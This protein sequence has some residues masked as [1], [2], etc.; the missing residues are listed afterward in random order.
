VTST[1]PRLDRRLWTAAEK[2]DDPSQPIAETW[3]QVCALA[4]ELGIPLPGYDTIRRIVVAHRERRAEVKR[5]LDP[6]ITDALQG[7][8][9]PWDLDRMIEAGIVSRSGRRA[10]A[11]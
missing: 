2:L 3:R 4:G 9:S 5:L 10:P 8:L 1:S 11:P 7:R 6:V